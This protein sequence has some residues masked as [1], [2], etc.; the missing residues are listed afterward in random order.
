MVKEKSKQPE[1]LMK[2]GPVKTLLL[3]GRK[4]LALKSDKNKV[5]G[6][7]YSARKDF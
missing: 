5:L 4:M 1:A 7:N 6:C 2:T 3:D